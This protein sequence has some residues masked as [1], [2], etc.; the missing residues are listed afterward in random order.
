MSSSLSTTKQKPYKLKENTD[1][2]CAYKY[3]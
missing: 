1:L 2:K 3:A